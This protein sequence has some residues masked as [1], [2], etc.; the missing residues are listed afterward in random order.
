M[1]KI[2][3]VC[4]GR[5]K[6]PFYRQAVEEYLKRLGRFAEVSVFELPECTFRGEDVA[7]VIL[8]TEG[9]AIARAVK[10]YTAVLAVEGKR[11]SSPDF[12]R[13]LTSVRDG[14]NP[15][16]SFVIGG[17]YGVHDSVKRRADKLISFSDMTFP[18]MLMR[19]ILAEQ[20]YRGFMIAA[21]SDY[22][23]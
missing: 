20:I 5:I 21:G 8:R 2:Q 17:S 14:G 16:M 9:E 4:V 1:F 12:S 15:V 22:H 23:K 19:V 18:H 7:D 6:E 13:L 10:G 11:F 3:L